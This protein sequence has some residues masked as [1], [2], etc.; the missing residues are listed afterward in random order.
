MD[1]KYDGG[2]KSVVCYRDYVQSPD[3]RSAARAFRKKFGENLM[4]PAIK[5]HERF[6]NY[7]SAGSYNAMYGSTDNRIEIKRAVK[8]RD[9]LVLKVRVDRSYRKFFNHLKE[10][11]VILL[12]KDWQGDFNA[13]TVI[14]VT[15]VNNHDYNN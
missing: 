7:S 2:S 13:V 3:D 12:K 6:L 1:I 4:S 10:D 15:D 8:D 5:L 9:A 11:S 14:F